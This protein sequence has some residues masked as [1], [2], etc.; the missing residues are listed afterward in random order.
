MLQEDFNK[1]I[2]SWRGFAEM[3]RNITITAFTTLLRNNVSYICINN[4]GFI[5]K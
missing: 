2:S 4:S 5:Q 3:G 1:K